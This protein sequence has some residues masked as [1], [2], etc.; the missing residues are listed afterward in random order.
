MKEGKEGAEGAAEE[1]NV[2]S[3]ADGARER[4]LVRIEPSEDA[5]EEGVGGLRGLEIA[6]EFE[7]LW[8]EGKDE[9]E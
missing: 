3:I 9:S 2:I 8:E 5:I 7:K 4:L 1:D 6:V